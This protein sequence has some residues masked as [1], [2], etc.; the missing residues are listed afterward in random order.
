MDRKAIGD[1][2]LKEAG[3]RLVDLDKWSRFEV[4]RPSTL[5]EPYKETE[6]YIVIVQVNK[7]MALLGD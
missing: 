1:K 6:N 3:H 4:S 5:R 2:L 7:T